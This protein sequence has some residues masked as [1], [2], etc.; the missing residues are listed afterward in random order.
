VLAHGDAIE[1]EFALAAGDGDQ[2]EVGGAAADVHHQDQIAHSHAF[3]PVGVAFDPGVESGLRLFEQCEIAVAGLNGGFQRQFARH[4]IE[5]SRHRYQHLLL[6]ERSLRHA[7][8][9]GL[10]QVLQKPAAGF[11][12][13]NPADAFRSAKRHQ[14]R[15]AVYTRMRQ[16]ALGRGHQPPGILRAPL[17]GQPSHH[18][19]PVR[20]P[21]QHQRSSR[22]VGAARQV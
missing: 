8:V 10:A 7:R 14:R 11:D 20:V 15:C 3:A 17:L 9:P 4:R 2:G 12:G 21:G 16:P 19:I 22:K 6:G 13:R 1:R 5:G 18:E